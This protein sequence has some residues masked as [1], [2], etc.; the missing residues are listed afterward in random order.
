MYKVRRSSFYFSECTLN[1]S[2]DCSI[3][4]SPKGALF[5]IKSAVDFESWSDIAITVAAP[6]ATTATKNLLCT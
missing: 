2:C 1:V 4:E 5:V 3:R 6:T